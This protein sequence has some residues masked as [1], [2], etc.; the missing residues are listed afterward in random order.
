MRFSDITGNE[1][2]KRA[3]VGMA[4]SGRVAHAML[5]YENDGCGALA[6]AL[7]YASYLGCRCHKDGDSCGEC[8]SCNRIFKLIHPDIHFVFPTNSGTKCSMA[9]KDI[10]SEV[11]LKEFRELV[12]SNPYF[13]ESDLMEALGLENKTWDINVLEAKKLI[14]KLSFSPVEDG[15]KTVIVYLPEKLNT[16]AANKLLKIVEEPPEKTLFLFITH[17][18]EKVLQT[19]FSRCQSSRIVP[20]SREEVYSALV[21]MGEGEEEAATAAA[22]SGGSVGVALRSLAAAE[23]QQLFLDLTTDLLGAVAGR[24]LLLAQ[25]VAEQIADLS[26]RSR[27][28][29]FCESLSETLRKIFLVQQKL[30]SLVLTTST[31]DLLVRNM[32]S[33]LPRNFVSRVLPV[34]DKAIYHIDRNVNQ[35]ILFSDL[36]NRMFVTIR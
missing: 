17:N 27:Q 12:L 9:A 30:D 18:P 2:V 36:V 3:L 34:L 8:P 19:I 13:L 11:Y 7:A 6:L 31:D 22:V 26:S 16:Q 14:E 15:Y 29:A 35:K 21:N 28:K 24:D 4:D 1:D 5:F 25:S 10:T 32:A 33:K 23:D 20:L